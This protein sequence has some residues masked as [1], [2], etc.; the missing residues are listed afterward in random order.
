[1][2]EQFNKSIVLA[3]ISDHLHFQELIDASS[4]ANEGDMTW[5]FRILSLCPSSLIAELISNCDTSLSHALAE[6][7]EDLLHDGVLDED[8]LAERIRS[9]ILPG[10]KL[11]IVD[12]VG[13]AVRPVH[14]EAMEKQPQKL[15][16]RRTRRPLFGERK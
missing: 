9:G 7:I 4:S 14:E 15:A 11:G 12:G 3:I 16:H 10:Q 6:V 2:I 8:E 1:M 13:E 5:L